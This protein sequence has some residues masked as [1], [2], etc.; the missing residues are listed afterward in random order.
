M[1]PLQVDSFLKYIVFMCFRDSWWG[2]LVMFFCTEPNA[3]NLLLVVNPLNS[4]ANES[5]Y[6]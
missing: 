2:F 6:Q 4:L 5:T 3:V 1:D